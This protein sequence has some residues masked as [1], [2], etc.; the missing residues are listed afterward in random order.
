MFL[1]TDYVYLSISIKSSYS[2]LTLSF[3]VM[4]V[5]IQTSILMA[6]SFSFLSLSIMDSKDEKYSALPL[7]SIEWGFTILTLHHEIEV[8]VAKTNHICAPYFD[9]LAVQKVQLSSI[10]ICTNSCTCKLYISASMLY[11][12]MCLPCIPNVI[13][14]THASFPPQVGTS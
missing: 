7:E 4:V 14:N 6:N 11:R 13:L 12:C 1:V 10:F 9:I 8:W 3:G 2:I 5:M